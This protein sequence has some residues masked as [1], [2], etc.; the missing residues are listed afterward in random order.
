MRG[1]PW[2]VQGEKQELKAMR[3]AQT[4]DQ[5]VGTWQI[6]ETECNSHLKLS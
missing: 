3:R 4:D 2:E 6:R 5:E 1:Q